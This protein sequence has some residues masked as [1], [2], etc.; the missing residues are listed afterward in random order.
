MVWVL[1]PYLPYCVQYLG[2]LKLGK[3][4]VVCGDLGSEQTGG[5]PRVLL[6]DRVL[7]WLMPGCEEGLWDHWPRQQPRHGSREELFFLVE[8]QGLSGLRLTRQGG[9]KPPYAELEPEPLVAIHP[10]STGL[11]GHHVSC[12]R[13]EKALEECFSLVEIP[14]EERAAGENRVGML[15]A[16]MN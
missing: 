13:E 12:W 5:A 8:T 4:G 9:R 14:G 15:L 10:L 7:C 1:K 2:S 11:L 16:Q 6:M 3:W